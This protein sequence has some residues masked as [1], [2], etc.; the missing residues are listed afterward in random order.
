MD[1][2]KVWDG[3]W[4]QRESYMRSCLGDITA[5]A[6]M[7][8][9]RISDEKGLEYLSALNRGAVRLLRALQQQELARRLQAED[10]AVSL[11]HVDLVELC[12]RV[13][14]E[15]G[16]L[17]AEIGIRVELHTELD[18]LLT[19]GEEEL[20]E[21]MLLTLISNGAKAAGEDGTVRIGLRLFENDALLTVGDRGE[22]MD[23]R[24]LDVMGAEKNI[25]PDLRPEAGAGGGLALARQIAILHGGALVARFPLGGGTRVVVSL[26]IR[27]GEALGLEGPRLPDSGYS[28][29]LVEL[30]DVL[31]ARLFLPER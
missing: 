28:R 11:A 4:A 3:V 20:L 17:L 22:R 9:R 16:E 27:T 21:H 12:R 29:S 1:R 8:G 13:C 7:L 18:A 6:Q 25:V 14:K 19:T 30:S 5:A 15:S 31:P 24:A 23:E 26:P 2:E 10:A